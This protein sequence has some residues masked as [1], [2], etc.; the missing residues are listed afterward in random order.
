MQ[1]DTL[2]APDVAD[3][4]AATAALLPVAATEQHGPHLPLGTDARLAT[5]LAEAL[6][7]A[8]AERLLVLPTQAVGCSA[9]HMPFPGTLTLRHE[10]FASVLRETVDAL[11]RHG[12]R[13]VLVLNSHGGNRAIGAVVAEQASTLWPE[14][15]IV[16]GSW[17][18]MAAPR[19][20]S[21]VEGAHP[22]TG[23]AG[24]FE[25]SLMLY[26]HPELV[27]MTQARDDGLPAPAPP[28][29]VN[30]FRSPR[31]AL[32]RSFAQMTERGVLGKPTL[33]SA[34]KGR[35]ILDETVPAIRELLAATW[36]DAPG[37]Q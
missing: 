3:L 37:V 31:A 16:F 6:D 7:A 4:P 36:P 2:R 24:E 27:D 18:D 30:L 19:I 5:R 28:Y 32:V 10:T 8:C 13:R 17:W 21:M 33:A 9:H 34:E 25:T 26:W 12:F 22:S 14:A 23:H 35:R 1:L 15:Q 29:E 11:T 20:Q